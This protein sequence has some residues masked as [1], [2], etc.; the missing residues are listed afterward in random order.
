MNHCGSEELV[1]EEEQEE[2]EKTGTSC[3][4]SAGLSRRRQV[5]DAFW[6]SE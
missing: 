5:N 2:E 1:V 6:D 3:M 4:L